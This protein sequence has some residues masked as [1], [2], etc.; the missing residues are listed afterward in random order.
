[1]ERK[2]IRNC[3]CLGSH[4]KNSCK[5]SVLFI[6][7]ETYGLLS[8]S[9][10]LIGA[11]AEL[12]NLFN[13]SCFGRPIV[14]ADADKQWFQL[15]LEEA[16]YLSHDLKCLKIIGEDKCPKS[17]DEVWQYM[18]SKK[19]MFPDFYKAYSHLRT[20]N[21]VVRSGSQYGVDYVAYRH[22]PAL[23]HSEYAVLVSSEGAGNESPRLKVWSD[24]H[25]TIRLC[26]SVAKTMLVLNIK[27]NGHDASSPS[28][29]EKFNV[30]ELTIRRW[31]PERCRED[32]QQT[33]KNAVNRG[34][35]NVMA[36][37]VTACCSTKASSSVPNMDAKIKS[38]H[39]P[40][41]KTACKK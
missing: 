18:K 9:V 40:S 25:C 17:D 5:S 19:T 31:N 21:W 1:M 38:H 20:K 39:Q 7:S 16:F 34:T 22:H 12:T 28:C 11:T 4:V 8:G 6:Q 30:G 33:I 26:G 35:A 36:W 37:T 24:F 10:V 3:R 41:V 14:T 32:E 2:G 15:S 13:R 29:L 27:K 23:V